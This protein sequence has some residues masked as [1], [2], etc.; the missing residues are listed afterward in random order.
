MNSWHFYDLATGQL[1][2]RTLHAPGNE[3][4]EANIPQG[5]GALE[6]EHDP[7]AGYVVDGA[8]VAYTDAQL[9]T[10]AACPGVGWVWNN[11]TFAWDDARML[12]QAKAQAWAR[13]KQAR[14]AAIAGGTTV[15]GIP[16]DTDEASLESLSRALQGLLLSQ[17]GA[18]IDLTAA[19]N[20]VHTVNLVQ[21]KAVF[22]AIHANTQAAFSAGQAA[23]V[24]INAATT[25]A[26]ADAISFSG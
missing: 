21:L 10:R 19:D 5:C 26:A 12:A 7:A 1:T 15:A 17:A 23:R 11:T 4:L 3:Q 25:N 22:M 14:T 8:F 13:V 20:T 24:A 6:G 9:A 2:G 16:V 18:T